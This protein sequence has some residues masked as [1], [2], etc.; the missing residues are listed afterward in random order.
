MHRAGFAGR[1]HSC[2]SGANHDLRVAS[3]AGN[4][5]RC[6]AANLGVLIAMWIDRDTLS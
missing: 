5:A 3:S 4:L 2:R 6:A 1:V